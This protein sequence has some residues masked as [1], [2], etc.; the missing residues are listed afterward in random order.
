MQRQRNEFHAKLRDSIAQDDLTRLLV[1]ATA[2]SS[3]LETLFA[4]Q[5]SKHHSLVSLIDQNLSAQDKILAA[6]TDAYARTADTRKSVDEI[7]KRRELTITSLITSYDA[8]EDLLS[9]STKGLEFYRKL[10]VNV[11]KLLQRVKSTCKVQEEERE[12]ILAR[13]EKS[14]YVPPETQ[15][16]PAN[17]VK[18]PGSGMKLRD[19]L[20]ARLKNN[21]V[22]TYQQNNYAPDK[23]AIPVAPIQ[24]NVHPGMKVYPIDPSNSVDTS[25]IPVHAVPP[26]AVDP[27]N[28]T[29][30]IY[31]QY[32]PNEYANYYMTQQQVPYHPQQYPYSEDP[33]SNGGGTQSFPRTGTTNTDSMYRTATGNSTGGTEVSSNSSR[34]AGYNNTQTDH[35]SSSPAPPQQA[36][37]PA[38]FDNPQYAGDYRPL[39]DNHGYQVHASMPVQPAISSSGYHCATSTI[40]PNYN[41]GNVNNIPVNQSPSHVQQP[42]MGA[43]RHEETRQD[44]V[45]PQVQNLMQRPQQQ[46]QQSYENTQTPYVHPYQVVSQT[47]QPPDSQ[48]AHA[49]TS[50]MVTPNSQ[51]NQQ[52]PTHVAT[53]NSPYVVPE[54]YLQSQQSTGDGSSYSTMYTVS[55]TNVPALLE[56]FDRF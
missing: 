24:P 13:N 10:E 15:I 8:Y 53:A 45:K 12:Q 36:Q 1:T 23:H 7:L 55:M 17:T 50:A 32:Y 18:K 6:L 51:S 27:N 19:H 20:A 41:A 33:M 48:A 9:K 49:Y 16:A 5:I 30:Q 46:V 28:P 42:S 52:L 38:H 22:K 3:S 4:E 43:Y 21:N 14:T 31:Q 44:A 37:Y 34:Y 39:Q 56:R 40:Q 11:T 2:E 29:Q 25:G 35:I 26:V 47:P 54:Q